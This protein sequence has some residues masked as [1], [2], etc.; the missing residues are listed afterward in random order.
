MTKRRFPAQQI[1]SAS[2]QTRAGA[3]AAETSGDS[4]NGGATHGRW[5]E[6]DSAVTPSDL[7]RLKQLEEDYSKLKQIV[8]GLDLD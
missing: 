2:R 7:E 1:A 6:T 8:A 5:R 3:A 4:G